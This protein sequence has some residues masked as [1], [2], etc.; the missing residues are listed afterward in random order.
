MMRY[1]FILL[2]GFLTIS[3]FGQT[4]VIYTENAPKPIGPYSQ[5]ILSGQT[6]YV[7]GQIAIITETGQIDTSSIENET[8]LVLKH[9]GSILKAA[10]MD[11]KDVVKSTIFTTDLKNFAKINEIYAQY[12]GTDPP[13]RETVQISKLPKNVHIEISVI[14]VKR[15]QMN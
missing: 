6:L 1:L 13:A 12:F 14:A 5:A 4:K 10:K 15:N 7:S 9:I 11:Y 8:D 2:S 3:I